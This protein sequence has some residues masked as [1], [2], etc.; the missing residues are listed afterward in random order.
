[1]ALIAPVVGACSHVQF[2]FLAEDTNKTQT[3]SKPQTTIPNSILAGQLLL[4]VVSLASFMVAFLTPNLAKLNAKNAS[5][6]IETSTLGIWKSC[7][8]DDCEDGGSELFDDDETVS[9][10]PK[11]FGIISIV[12]IGAAILGI[13]FPL[14]LARMRRGTK[15]SKKTNEMDSQRLLL[16]ANI[17][18]GLL[19]LGILFM[20]AATVIWY[21]Y[22]FT[23]LK[24]ELTLDDGTTLFDAQIDNF[25]WGSYLLFSGGTGMILTALWHA[26]TT[27]Y[28]NLGRVGVST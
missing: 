3:M 11:A 10:L 24:K 26:Q 20:I 15:E 19:V 18:T 7:I 6:D 13:A 2:F 16:A 21:Y 14:M 5:V 17:T 4:A 27:S 12:C 9:R 25:D 8:S 28:N 1:M 22:T 23:N